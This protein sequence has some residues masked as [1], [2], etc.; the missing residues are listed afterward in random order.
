MRGWIGILTALWLVQP[1][2][3]EEW[4]TY[5][6]ASDDGS[7]KWWVVARPSVDDPET[8][9]VLRCHT[10]AA[11]PETAVYLELGQAVS[12]PD[13]V[14][15]L[16]LT[17]DGEEPRQETWASASGGSF[18]DAPQPLD[19]ARRLPVASRLTVAPRNEMAARSFELAGLGEPAENLARRCDWNASPSSPAAITLIEGEGDL[20][21]IDT[22]LVEAPK[23]L[24]NPPP[25]YT[26][27]ARQARVQ[28]NIIARAIIDQEGNVKSA[29]IL[30]GLEESLDR[31]TLATIS[32]WKFEPALYE[33]KP[34]MV[35][36]NLTVN[37]LLGGDTPTGFAVPLSENAA[38]KV[39]ARWVRKLEKLDED[40]AQ[41]RWPAV[42]RS[43]RRLAEEM[44]TRVSGRGQANVLL[45]QGPAFEA[46]AA[47]AVGDEA[48]AEWAWWKSQGLAAFDA[49]RFEALAAAVGDW[50]H[51]PTREVGEGESGAVALSVWGDDAEP[52]RPIDVAGP[53]PR[54]DQ[55]Q[56]WYASPVQ[57]EVVVSTSGRVRSPRILRGEVGAMVFRSIERMRDWR[58][59]PAR[60]DGRPV[61]SL[62]RLSLLGDGEVELIQ[63]SMRVVGAVAAPRPSEELTASY[64]REARTARIEGEVEVEAAIDTT[65]AVVRT[66]VLDGLP[67][68]LNQ[69]ARDAVKAMEFEPATVDGRAV[70]ALVPVIVIYSLDAASAASD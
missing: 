10:S 70:P 52:A 8:S 12:A 11:G 66:R 16:T 56:A 38:S 25:P 47:A 44:A 35:Y 51:V 41:A 20:G 7:S 23:K 26:D 48:D 30:R 60:L 45:A 21:E 65:G 63:D 27:Q 14:V 58:F 42:R 24:Y 15:T 28:G 9:L 34:V 61:A 40:V 29:E 33:G 2:M 69:V 55:V 13:G 39:L 32:R 5:V 31:S 3:A 57:V 18:L 64:T 4:R 1:G 22:R 43:A 36:Y 59:H 46:V 53:K 54:S 19:L 50:L 17:L 67:M 37:F 49:G 68:G 6:G 62:L